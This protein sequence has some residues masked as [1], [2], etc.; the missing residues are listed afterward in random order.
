MTNVIDL[1]KERYKRKVPEEYRR[2]LEV[3][4]EKDQKNSPQLPKPGTFIM[5]ESYGNEW[6]QPKEMPLRPE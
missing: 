4:A 5:Q 3:L 6:G 1:L 2:L